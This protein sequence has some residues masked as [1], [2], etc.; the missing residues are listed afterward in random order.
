LTSRRLLASGTS[1]QVLFAW[2]HQASLFK[3]VVMIARSLCSIKLSLALQLISLFRIHDCYYLSTPRTSRAVSHRRMTQLN[4]FMDLFGKGSKSGSTSAFVDSSSAPSWD[5]IDAM[6]RQQESPA[7]RSD[8]DDIL[9]GRGGSSHKA[10]I[11]LFDAA[12]DFEPEIT[13]YRDTAGW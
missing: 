1:R 12:D 13:L 4:G 10:S 9:K 8:F 6:L 11:R 2:I 7:E 5:E 3:A